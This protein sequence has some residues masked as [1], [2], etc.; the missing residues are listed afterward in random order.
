MTRR[1]RGLLVRRKRASEL[2]RRLADHLP[3]HVRLGLAPQL[4]VEMLAPGVSPEINR[5]ANGRNPEEPPD[6][7]IGVETKGTRNVIAGGGT[8]SAVLSLLVAL[9]ERSEERRVGKECR[10]RGAA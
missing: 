6:E 5:L 4:D 7:V 9:F 8:A 1:P 3:R 10:S 2:R